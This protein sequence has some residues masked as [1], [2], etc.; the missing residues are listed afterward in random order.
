MVATGSAVAQ[1]KLDGLGQSRTAPCQREVNS[2][3]FMEV[4]RPGRARGRPADRNNRPPGP[5]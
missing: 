3:P 4:G 2:D 1:R 5:A